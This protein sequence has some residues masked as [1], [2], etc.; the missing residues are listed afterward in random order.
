[1]KR[2]FWGRA[3]Q[4]AAGSHHSF[5][6]QPVNGDAS[7][8]PNPKQPSHIGSCLADQQA[9]SRFKA[10][11]SSDGS[12][13]ALVSQRNQCQDVT[14]HAG[15]LVWVHVGLGRCGRAFLRHL[16]PGFTPLL[17]FGEGLGPPAD[18]RHRSARPRGLGRGGLALAPAETPRRQSRI[19][20]IR[21]RCS[22]QDPDLLLNDRNDHVQSGVQHSQTEAVSHVVEGAA[23][24]R[25]PEALP[26][27]LQ[28]VPERTNPPYVLQQNP[29]PS[30]FK[31]NGPPPEPEYRITLKPQRP[32][33]VSI[34][35][36]Q[37]WTVFISGMSCFA[38]LP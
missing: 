24:E 18:P 23:V 10:S 2:S 1:M 36:D 3:P 5:K 14:V 28:V 9:G 35:L 30:C 8:G 6:A 11:A 12:G 31:A 16:L 38:M 13:N 22:R 19:G 26:H 15:Q 33:F 7:G 4:E 25:I 32:Y 37:C 20:R 17:Q 21:S 27:I 29:E 34:I